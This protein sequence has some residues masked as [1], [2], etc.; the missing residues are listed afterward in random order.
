MHRAVKRFE[1]FLAGAFRVA[2]LL[3]VI[4]PMVTGVP[5]A[6]AQDQASARRAALVFRIL[7]Y[8]RNLRQRS[9]ER[10]TVLVAYRDGNARSEAESRGIAGAL[11]AL[12][13]R[14]RIAGL[15]GRA[16]RYRFQGA[17]DLQR[18]VTRESAAAVYV[19]D[20]LSEAVSDISRISRAEDVLSLASE[21][22]LARRGLGVAIAAEE[23][24]FKLIVN[25]RAVREEGTRLDAALLR[26]AEIL[27]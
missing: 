20:G 11:N 12:G 7:S 8:D 6:A 26:L 4:A 16:L 22:G 2:V 5:V 3:T 17:A 24:T 19:C 15:P 21:R 9:G 25:L 10:V 23:G 1:A 27:R 14:T 18:A 13:R